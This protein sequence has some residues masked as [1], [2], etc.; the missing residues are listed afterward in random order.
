MKK[1]KLHLNDEQWRELSQ[2]LNALKTTM[3]GKGWHTD[4]VDDLL[5]KVLTAKT[6]RVKIAV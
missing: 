4:D 3:L 5:Y 6:K 2:S 1:I